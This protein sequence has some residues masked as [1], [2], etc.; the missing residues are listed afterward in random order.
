[1]AIGTVDKLGQNKARQKEM[2]VGWG[3]VVRKGPS[4]TGRLSRNQKK[5]RE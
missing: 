4:D 3:R 5:A 2:K 1:M